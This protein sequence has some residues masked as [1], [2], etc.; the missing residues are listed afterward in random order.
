MFKTFKKWWKKRMKFSWKQIPLLFLFSATCI[1]TFFIFQDTKTAKYETA[2]RRISAVAKTSN[3]GQ[4]T[5]NF[6]PKLSK[7]DETPEYLSRVINDT[8]AFNKTNYIIYDYGKNG[9]KIRVIVNGEGRR[10]YVL[11]D[12]PTNPTFIVSNL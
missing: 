12:L 11:P 8:K 4:L 7:E 9:H 10:D 2:A 6:Y 3:N 5:A 1:S